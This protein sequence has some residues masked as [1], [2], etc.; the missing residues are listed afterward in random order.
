VPEGV[1][2]PVDGT[3]PNTLADRRRGEY[4]AKWGK[5]LKGWLCRE[6]GATVVEYALILALFAMV[7]IGAIILVE[8]KVNN[9]FNAV[10]N[11]LA[12][13]PGYEE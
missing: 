4:V 3:T 10:V 12:N 2:K 5:N 7:V 11:E 8:R 13:P 6:K 9:S 1:W